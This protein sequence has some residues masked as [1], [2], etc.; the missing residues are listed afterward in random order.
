MPVFHFLTKDGEIKEGYIL[1]QYEAW[2][3]S[4]RYI[5]K[6]YGADKQYRCIEAKNA[7][8]KPYTFIELTV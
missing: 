3:G 1:R 7:Y 6:E 2:E 4:M 5:I 8:C